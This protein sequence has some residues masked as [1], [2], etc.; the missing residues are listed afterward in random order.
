MWEEAAIS[1]LPE[2]M[3]VCFEA[4]SDVMKEME[5]KITTHEGRSYHIYN[6]KEAM[7]GL[8]RAYFVEANWFNTKYMPTFEEYLSISVMSS[9][10]PMLA[11]Q[12]LVGIRKIATKEAFNVPKIVKSC[13]LIA[14]LVDDIQTHKVEQERGDVPSGVRCY[15]REHGVSEEEACGKITE[16]VDI[17]WKDINEELQNPNRLFPLPL[18]LPTLNLSR[19]ME[20]IYVS[21]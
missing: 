5:D 9:G 18:L 19:M 4:L 1:D 15:I 17:A 2:Y 21:K 13:A 3:Q 6:A 7:K 20:V 8:V 11:V 10:Y 12:S 16:M 14:R